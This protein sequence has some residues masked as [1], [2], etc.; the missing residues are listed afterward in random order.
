MSNLK[1]K[2]R[3]GYN[4]DNVCKKVCNIFYRISFHLFMEQVCCSDFKEAAT[5]GVL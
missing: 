5:G 1:N 2:W 3:V 4:L